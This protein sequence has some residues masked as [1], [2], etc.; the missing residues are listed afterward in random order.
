MTSVTL[1]TVLR[2]FVAGALLAGAPLVQAAS[3][4]LSSNVGVD[5]DITL[6]N[7]ALNYTYV[8]VCAR[9]AGS[10]ATT[11]ICGTSSGSG[12]SKTTWNG[13]QNWSL[14]YGKLALN[15][16]TTGSSMT[17]KAPSTSP[18]VPVTGTYVAGSGATTSA[19]Q[20]Y[21]LSVVFGFNAG[22][23]ALSGLLASDPWTGDALTSSSLAVKGKTTT[24]GF[25][26]GTLVTGTPTSALA[27][28]YNKAYQFG[29][30]GASKAGIFEFVFN[31][32]GGDYR[33]YSTNQ[34]GIIISTG[35]TGFCR[36]V[37]TYTTKTCSGTTPTTSWDSQGI[38]FW[39]SNF[40]GQAN[41]DTFVPVPA[42]V[43]LF[44]SALAGLTVAR[45]RKSAASA[46]A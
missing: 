23:T 7:G 32:I 30:A 16:Q 17:L 26:S 9:S 43:W 31:N 24:A 14:S 5:P 2:I 38:N 46:V 42:A 1:R 45:R 13:A 11:G 34:G 29:Y 8:A 41:A 28:P 4:G 44:G 3:I 35:S 39:K 20:N 15:Y 37:Y 40:S 33:A 12:S 25:T 36:G 18:P 22:G 19:S 6:F 27:P 10:G 21:N